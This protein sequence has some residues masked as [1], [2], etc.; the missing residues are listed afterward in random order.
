MFL[1]YSHYLHTSIPTCNGS[2]LLF[3]CCNC[4]YNHRD[5]YVTTIAGTFFLLSNPFSRLYFSSH[6]ASHYAYIFLNS[7]YNLLIMQQIFGN[8]FF[9]LNIFTISYFLSGFVLSNT[10]TFAAQ[11][12]CSPFLR[13]QESQ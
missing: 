7:F 4:H 9:L 3:Y 11:E 2:G 6:I 10:R 1:T 5:I 13:A 8:I 12:F